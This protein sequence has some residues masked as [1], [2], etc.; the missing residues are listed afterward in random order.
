MIYSNNCVYLRVVTQSATLLALQRLGGLHRQLYF[1]RFADFVQLTVLQNSDSSKARSKLRKAAES[2]CAIIK[3]RV[4]KMK[5][6]F[7]SSS[8]CDVAKYLTDFCGEELKGKTVTFI[9]T[10]SL[11]EEYAG[12]VE[13][14]KK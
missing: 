9:P 2:L 7:L 8:F 5:K 1:S 12:Y 3:P 11:V 13:N 10:A 14:D 6:L 4:Q